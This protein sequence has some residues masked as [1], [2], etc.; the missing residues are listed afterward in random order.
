MPSCRGSTLARWTSLVYYGEEARKAGVKTG[1]ISVRTGVPGH[2]RSTVMLLRLIVMR[3][4]AAGPSPFRPETAAVH[5]GRIML[6]EM[7]A[8][9]QQRKSF[10]FETALSG[11]MYA[12]KIQRWQGL[13]YH[14]GLIF[15]KLPNVE[16][17]TAR[18]LARVAQGGHNVPE[19]VIR[20]R[21]IAGLRNFDKIY[22]DTVDTWVLYDNS[23][24]APVLLTWGEKR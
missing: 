8:P 7:K 11:R 1:G 6:Q 5:A 23:G 10:A 21:F 19:D 4:I 14:V 20:R 18:V 15:L 13:G 17:A 22:R 16:M 24:S 9:V 2:D 3:L 12:Q